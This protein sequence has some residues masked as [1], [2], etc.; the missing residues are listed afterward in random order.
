MPCFENDPL[1]LHDLRSYNSIQDIIDADLRQL[2][3]SSLDPKLDYVSED[4]VDTACDQ[5]T[6][7]PL[8]PPY[9]VND[10]GNLVDPVAANKAAERS[11][12][13]FLL[14]WEAIMI[15]CYEDEYRKVTD[16]IIANE[17]TKKQA[18]VR[19]RYSKYRSAQK[20]RAFIYFDELPLNY[21]DPMA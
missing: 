7:I 21:T 15:V 12:E 2:H 11:V 18:F 13:L 19:V 17:I 1:D 20:T 4:N 9:F 6:E 8:L 16:W 3:L 5:G 14:D 10:F